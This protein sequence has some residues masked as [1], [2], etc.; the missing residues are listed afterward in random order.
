LWWHPHNFARNRSENFGRLERLLDEFAVLAAS[1]GLRS[2]SMQ[3]VVYEA[4]GRI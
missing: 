1:E 3:D 4:M 2:M